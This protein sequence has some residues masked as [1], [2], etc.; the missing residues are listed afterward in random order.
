M[1][2]GGV[3]KRGFSYILPPM[4]AKFDHNIELP[5]MPIVIMVLVLVAAAI[6]VVAMIV[7]GDAPAQ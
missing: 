2:A 3:Q 4:S 7:F 1:D 5:P 6:G